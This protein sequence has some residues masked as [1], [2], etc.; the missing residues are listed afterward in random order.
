M[1]EPILS[2]Q[3]LEKSVNYPVNRSL[4]IGSLVFCRFVLTRTI[5][6]IEL[7]K[8]VTKRTSRVFRNCFA[9]VRQPIQVIKAMMMFLRIVPKMAIRIE[10]MQPKAQ[11]L[12][13][14]LTHSLQIFPLMTCP[15]CVFV[16]KV[17]MKVLVIPQLAQNSEQKHCRASFFSVLT[18]FSPFCHQMTAYLS[19]SAPYTAFTSSQSY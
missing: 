14:T 11:I 16:W 7:I 13:R 12:K 18:S 8:Y 6:N 9:K 19:K 2:Y 1:I 5:T 15:E 17:E 4:S 10:N 3:S